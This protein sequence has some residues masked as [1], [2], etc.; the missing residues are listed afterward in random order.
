MQLISWRNG[1]LAQKKMLTISTI[2]EKGKLIKLIEKWMAK[3]TYHESNT[4]VFFSAFKLYMN[5]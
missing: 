4:E 1:K 3:N 2:S 5:T